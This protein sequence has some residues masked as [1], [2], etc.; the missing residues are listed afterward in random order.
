MDSEQFQGSSPV[1]FIFRVWDSE[2]RMASDEVSVQFLAE[3]WDLTECG[4]LTCA[5]D[6]DCTR[7][8][9]FH[10]VCDKAQWAELGCCRCAVP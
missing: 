4:V 2:G 3:D 10:G 8:C 6:A 7:A 5:D 1:A 9:V